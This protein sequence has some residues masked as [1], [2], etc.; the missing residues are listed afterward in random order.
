MRYIVLI[1]QPLRT[2]RYLGNVETHILRITC[3]FSWDERRA[4]KRWFKGYHIKCCDPGSA[5]RLAIKKTLESKISSYEFPCETI[6][7]QIIH[8]P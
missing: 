8:Y 3:D 6:G 1:V 5:I 7:S 2:L 4:I